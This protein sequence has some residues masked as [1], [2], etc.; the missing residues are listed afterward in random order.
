M[1]H[2]LFPIHC[3]VVVNKPSDYIKNVQYVDE[4][5][6]RVFP[7]VNMSLYCK[8]DKIQ[9]VNMLTSQSVTLI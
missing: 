8:N 2:P 3:S 5:K 1:I 9:D 6:L 4:T 7:G